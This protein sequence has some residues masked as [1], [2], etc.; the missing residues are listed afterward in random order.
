MSDDYQIEPRNGRFLLAQRSISD[1]RNTNFGMI[2]GYDLIG[3]FDTEDDAIAE[4][5]RLGPVTI[6]D[7]N[8]RQF[9]DWLRNGQ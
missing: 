5:K 1:Q 4:A 7:R 8:K 2:N 6:V 9:V 3:V